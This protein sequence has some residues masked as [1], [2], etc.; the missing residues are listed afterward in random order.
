MLKEIVKAFWVV[1]VAEMGDK[2]QVLAMTFAT[3]FNILEVLLGITIGVVLNHGIAIVLGRYLT[4]FIPMSKIQILSGAVFLIFG[5]LSLLDNDEDEEDNTKQSYGPI[6]TV[7][8]AFFLGELGDKTQLAAM[9]LA[10]ESSSAIFT[11]AGTTLAMLAT[12]SLGIVVGSK[13]GGKIPEEII[14]I[15]SSVVFLFFG[16]VKLYNTI[17]IAEPIVYVLALGLIVMIEILLIRRYLI[18]VKEKITPIRQAA[19]KLYEQTKML[20]KSIDS[21]CLG[22][23]KCGTCDGTSCLIGFIKYI[24]KDA[25]ANE[26]Y[27]MDSIIDVSKFINKGYSRES[28]IKALA[29]IIKDYEEY[30]WDKNPRFIVNQ[31]RLVI[32][33]ILLGYNIDEFSNTGTYLK[34]LKS[35]DEQIAYNV[36]K[37]IENIIL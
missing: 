33:E 17:D 9:T 11:L 35:K 32:E 23:D 15:A 21:I 12:S 29:L 8:L 1:F 22:E 24:L 3:R 34:K 30:G 6:I 4:K 2:T 13:V 18:S 31:I 25:R 27:Y 19:Q 37:E 10:A 14:K 36:I 16:I 28:L 26:Q 20:E 7:A 5:F